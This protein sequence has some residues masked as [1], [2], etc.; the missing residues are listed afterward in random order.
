MTST[1]NQSV[2]YI[3][4]GSFEQPL[5]PTQVTTDI[6]QR[7]ESRVSQD[8]IRREV[9]SSF[10]VK[11]L[12]PRP[13]FPR[14][15]QMVPMARDGYFR[16]IIPSDQG[17]LNKDIHINHQNGADV[18]SKQKLMNHPG[19][20]KMVG[21]DENFV[22]IHR[23]NS[24]IDVSKMTHHDHS[25]TSLNSNSSKSTSV[26]SSRSHAEVDAAITLATGLQS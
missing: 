21:G 16:E 15:A 17:M 20:P 5:S 6:H 19:S 11:P 13:T 4:F 12:N 23:H 26:T 25:N 18:L 1:S 3:P 7:S 14:Q 24:F 9:T 8:K 10:D 22:Y 2:T